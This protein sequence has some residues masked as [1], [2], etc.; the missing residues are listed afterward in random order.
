MTQPTSTM[1]EERYNTHNH[2]IN[3]NC[4]TQSNTIV[5]ENLVATIRGQKYEVITFDHSLFEYE[6]TKNLSFW[7]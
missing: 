1:Y 7:Q 3:K 6:V 2:D 5:R 4:K